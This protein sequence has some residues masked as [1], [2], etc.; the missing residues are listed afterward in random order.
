M[1][2]MSS[3]ALTMT[4]ATGRDAA[5]EDAVRAGQVV[6][7]RVLSQNGDITTLDLLG[8][9]VQAKL[10]IALEV[11]TAVPFRVI[12][13]HNGSVEAQLMNTRPTDEPPTYSP[14]IDPSLSDSATDVVRSVR[15]LVDLATNRIFGAAAP[16][17]NA[18][19]VL[20]LSPETL[21]RVAV[22]GDRPQQPLVSFE[23]E[24]LAASAAL[25]SATSEELL[26]AQ[27]AL[28]RL[29]VPATPL[30]IAAALPEANEPARLVS[31]LARMNTLLS[32]L[33]PE[34]RL[35]TLRTLAVFLSQIRPDENPVEAQISAFV[36]QIAAGGENKLFELLTALSQRSENGVSAAQRLLLT[37]RATERATSLTNDF[38]TQLMAV[39]NASGEDAS[40]AAI[41][42]EA[43]EVVTA[44]Q[45]T[46]LNAAKT[47][48]GAI[49]FVLPIMSG[50]T[51]LA[52]QLTVHRDTSEGRNRPMDAENFRISFSLN[53]KRLGVVR[54]DIESVARMLR[55]TVE[56]QTTRAVE[57]VRA[58]IDALR[59]RL[60]S[61][62]YRS[63][64]MTAQVV[65]RQP[66]RAENEDLDEVH[67]TYVQ[68]FKGTSQ[69]TNTVS[70]WDTHA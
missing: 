45:L 52:A 43:L 69:E 30:T 16:R 12:D 17:A 62:G 5:G 2:N 37:A 35:N 1:S 64:A 29:D 7:G 14:K 49:A 54:I 9:N 11:G 24:A 13:V 10:P 63:V 36:D 47:S 39:S 60:D 58:H 57:E 4:V 65:R 48:P 41:L 32:Q 53:T 46:S 28:E 56:V 8:Q 40:L 51:T 25:S 21:L 18:P 66:Y 70:R 34:G 50:R 31:V 22:R 55:V 33:S 20:D 59:D 68:S 44:A 61:R 27:A 3:G 23:P 67:R 42:T 15:R 19:K 26:A 6:Y 38:K